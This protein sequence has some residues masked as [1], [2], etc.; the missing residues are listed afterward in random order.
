MA[1]YSGEKGSEEL[2]RN[3][4]ALAPEV[5]TAYLTSEGG[6]A[7]AVVASHN[8]LVG[9]NAPTVVGQPIPG[10][11]LK[12]IEPG[13]GFEDIVDAGQ[14]GEIAVAGGSLA[15]GYLGDEKLTRE[16]FRKGWWR[17]GD[18]GV[19][20]RQG[21]L[22]IRGRKDNRINSGGIKIHAEEVESGLLEHPA[23]R[24]AAVI[25]VEDAEFGERIQAHVVVDDESI[26]P[27]DILKHMGRAELI[28]AA[29]LPKAI[30]FHD[31]LP[32][33]PTGKLYRKGLYG[34]GD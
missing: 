14:T 22:T 25:G 5:R 15:K 10:A 34:L 4:A 3:L 20:D 16:T 12:I 1:F 18:L 11:G 31:E 24:Q 29:L 19:I 26:S 21:Q 33:G 30:H 27:I 9:S 7:A 8:V 32:I 23:V 13:G 28:P 6:C 2:I 17:T